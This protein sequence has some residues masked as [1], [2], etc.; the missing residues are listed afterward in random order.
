MIAPASPRMAYLSRIRRIAAR[1]GYV[2]DGNHVF[3]LASFL[4]IQRGAWRASV[5]EQPDRHP[6]SMRILSRILA[7]AY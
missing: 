7:A 5:I 6:L 3:A 4:A 1:R 2:A